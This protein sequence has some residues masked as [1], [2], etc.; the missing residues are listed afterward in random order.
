MTITNSQ[1]REWF[2]NTAASN[3]MTGDSGTLVNLKPYSG[4]D[5]VM[6]G[7]GDLLNISHIGDTFLNTTNG[8][9]VMK[10]VLLVPRWSILKFLNDFGLMLLV[11]LSS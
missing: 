2:P 9:M 8:K 11:Q 3:H 4:H 1:D 7:N 5:S 6:V 10:K